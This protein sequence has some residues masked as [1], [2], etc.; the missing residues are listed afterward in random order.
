MFNLICGVVLGGIFTWIIAHWYY[1]R[2]AHDQQRL[3]GKLSLEVREL[4]LSDKRDSITVAQLNELL[5]K[6]TLDLS[7][8]N[9]LPYKVCPKCGSENLIRNRDFIVDEEPGDDGMA[10][11]VA[12]PY[13]TIGCDDCGWRDDEIDK[14][15]KR[16][17]D[18]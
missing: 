9:V 8:G 10:F 5:Q 7:S 3:F 16:I 2:S 17:M 18:N 12:T 13:K 4:I 11:Q 6:K 14:D 15:F 1:L